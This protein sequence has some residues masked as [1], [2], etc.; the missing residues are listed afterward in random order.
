M[1]ISSKGRYAVRVMAELAKHQE[2]FISVAE[3]SEKQ[4]ISIKYLEKIISM[5]NKAK[6]IESARGVTGG[7]KLN[8]PAKDY[9][10]AQILKATNDLPCLAPCLANGKDC[11]MQNR[12]N[13]IGCWEKLNMMIVDYLT[14]ITLEDLLNKTF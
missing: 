6:L 14:N 10:V 2:E 4:N 8:R 13:S 11:P 1:K 12:C 3:L 5:L 9:T 7:Y